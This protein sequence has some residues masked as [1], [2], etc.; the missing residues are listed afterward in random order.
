MKNCIH[1]TQEPALPLGDYWMLLQQV[2]GTFDLKD[3]DALCP[4]GDHTHVVVTIGARQAT[5]SDLAHAAA[6]LLDPSE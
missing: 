1:D 4:V 3:H 5:G 6:K 2:G